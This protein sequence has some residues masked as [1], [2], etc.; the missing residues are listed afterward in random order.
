MVRLYMSLG[1]LPAFAFVGRCLLAQRFACEREAVMAL[2]QPVQHG[3]GHVT[4][5]TVRNYRTLHVVCPVR[6][7]FWDEFWS[8]N[9]GDTSN[10]TLAWA[11]PASNPAEMQEYIASGE[12][13]YFAQKQRR[14]AGQII[15]RREKWAP[16]ESFAFGEAE[17]KPLRSGEASGR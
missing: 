6:D 1:V 11:H 9:N 10:P 15:L 7:D 4:P 8:A 12:V 16:P 5:W 2:H 17:L 13:H 14:N 3:V